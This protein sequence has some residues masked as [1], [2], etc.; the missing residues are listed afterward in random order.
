MDWIVRKNQIS[1]KTEMV[2]E[3]YE[4]AHLSDL[5]H[6]S[7]PEKELADL[8]ARAHSFQR[9]ATYNTFKQSLQYGGQA[10]RIRSA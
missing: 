9:Q 4:I 7:R 5:D 2:C 3:Q 1:R 8:F 10:P 6:F